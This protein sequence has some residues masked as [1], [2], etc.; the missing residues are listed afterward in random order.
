MN[1]KDLMAKRIAENDHDLVI[2]AANAIEEARVHEILK[3]LYGWKGKYVTVNVRG[4]RTPEELR[5]FL[6]SKDNT[7]PVHTLGDG[8]DDKDINKILEYTIPRNPVYTVNGAI[9]RILSSGIDV[10]ATEQT[11]EQG[12]IRRMTEIWVENL[13][14]T[15]LKICY[16]SDILMDRKEGLYAFVP[17][18]NEATYELLLGQLGKNGWYAEKLGFFDNL[19]G[20]QK[21][22]VI[23]HR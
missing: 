8:I 4:E 17:G 11:T 12:R 5:E 21:V 16:M 2:E 10:W 9:G 18:I 14:K 20:N 23:A 1:S 6:E 7:N 15:G 22:L 19:S 3:E 13:S